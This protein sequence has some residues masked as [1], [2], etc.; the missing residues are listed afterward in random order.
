MTRGLKQDGLQDG[1]AYIDGEQVRAF[2][3]IALTGRGRELLDDAQGESGGDETT[4][5]RR[6]RG[7]GDWD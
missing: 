6:D 2:H 5:R 1:H 7:L 4:D 3:D